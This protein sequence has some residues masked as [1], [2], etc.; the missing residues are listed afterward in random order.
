[1]PKS[2]FGKVVGFYRS[3]HRRCSL[4]KVFLERCSQNSQENTCDRD[5]I[6]IKLQ[7]QGCKKETLTQVFSCNF[8]KISE[9]TFSIEH[10]R[11]T[12]SAF[13]FSEAA[14]GGVLWKKV[15]L[16]ISQNS[17]EKTCGLRNFQEH[18]F[19]RTPLDNCFWI[20]RKTL[21]KWGSIRKP[22]MNPLYL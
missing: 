17:L 6:L 14:T 13:T 20:F 21:L 2:F 10:L 16:E 8:S 11:T 3:S 19:Y 15:F 7:A 22:Q 18:L 5:F 4:K 1:M 12:A 9:N